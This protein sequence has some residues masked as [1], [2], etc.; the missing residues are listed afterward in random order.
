VPGPYNA[1]ETTV[2]PYSD[3]TRVAE[4]AFL[5]ECSPRS[6]VSFQYGTGRHINSGFPICTHLSSS[7]HTGDWRSDILTAHAPVRN[8]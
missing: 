7:F 4:I 8:R 1:D 5:A 3:R 6:S 2:K